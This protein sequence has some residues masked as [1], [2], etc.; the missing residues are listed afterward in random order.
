[1]IPKDEGSQFGFE[2]FR[3]VCYET[4]LCLLWHFVRS[5]QS[6]ISMRIGTRLASAKLTF[7]S[8]LGPT[9][10]TANRQCFFLGNFHGYIIRRFSAGNCSILTTHYS[11]ADSPSGRL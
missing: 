10:R 9:H 11:W 7:L 1:M 8:G 2:N 5:R 6:P 3:F 4:I